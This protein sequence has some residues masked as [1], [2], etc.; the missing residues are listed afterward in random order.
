MATMGTAERSDLAGI[1]IYDPRGYEAAAPYET[2]ALLRREWSTELRAIFAMLGWA[3][4]RLGAG[5]PLVSL[6]LLGMSP[7]TLV[8]G[9]QVRG[10]GLGALAIAWSMA[11]LWSFVSR[12]SAARAAVAQAALILAAQSYFGN[13]FL[14]AAFCAA[15]SR[16][17]CTRR[18]RVSHPAP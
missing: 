2:F 4:R 7:T 5:V 9:G 3:A 11:A 6:L 1:D 13:C 15:G 18:P 17:V 16:V 12:P 8:Y 10:Y 14:V